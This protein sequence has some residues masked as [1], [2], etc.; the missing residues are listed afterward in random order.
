MPDLFSVITDKVE[1]TSAQISLYQ[2]GVILAAAEATNFFPGSPLISQTKLGDG[3]S[4]TFIKFAQL[5]DA[6]DLTDGVEEDSEAVTDSQVVITLAEKGKLVTSTALGNVVTG[7]RLDSALPLLI[8][9]NMGKKFD[10]TAIQTLEAST[11]EYF[12]NQESEAALTAGDI[13]AKSYFEKAYTYLRNNSIEPIV[14]GLY[15]ALVHPHVLADLR[16]QSAVG[17]WTPLAQYTDLMSVLR[18]E[19]GIYKGFRII[20]TANVTTN[21]N[22]GDGNVDT[23]HT[24]CFG[25]NALGLAMSSTAPP[26]MTITRNTDKFGDRF[27]HFGWW[28]IFSFG[29]IDTSASCIITSASSFGSNA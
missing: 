3:V 12:V 1:M 16:E 13:I 21:A 2:E 28:G 6:G 15:A 4:A 14:D 23:Y 10:T 5:G 7:G 25:Y 17:D 9:K 22:A 11:N 29:L 27:T 18:N 8:G 26:H 24:S 19:V 20:Q